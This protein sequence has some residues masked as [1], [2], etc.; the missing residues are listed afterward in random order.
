MANL[1]H[2]ITPLIYQSLMNNNAKNALERNP[3]NFAKLVVRSTAATL[4]MALVALVCFAP[5]ARAD[6]TVSTSDQAFVVAAAQINLT[7]IKLGEV[8]VQNAQ[9]EDVKDFGRRMVKDHTA[10]NEDLKT[11]AAQKNVVLPDS[12]DADNQMMVDK[13]T[14]LTGADFDHAYVSGMFKGHKKA[15]KAFKAESAA[16]SDADV[17]AF[18]DKT[19]PLLEE[20]LKLITDLRQ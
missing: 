5:H 6:A 7:E 16:T 3:L 1:N 9:R 11:L 19:L 13:L 14:A 20:H 2:P 8:A 12:L 4:L 17:K 10:I 15:V 18:A